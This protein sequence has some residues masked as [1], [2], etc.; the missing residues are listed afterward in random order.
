MYQVWG[1]ENNGMSI[2]CKLL[3]SVILIAGAT[4]FWTSS[5]EIDAH[6]LYHVLRKE[7]LSS[8]HEVTYMY[9]CKLQ[10]IVYSQEICKRLVLFCITVKSLILDA[11]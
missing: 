4:C 3:I 10:Y 5:Y 7:N 9:M 8:L 6:V 1:L 11:P 2:M